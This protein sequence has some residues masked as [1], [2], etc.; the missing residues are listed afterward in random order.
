MQLALGEYPKSV[1]GRCVVEVMNDM[2]RAITVEV[3]NSGNGVWCIIHGVNLNGP[4]Y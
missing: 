2:K 1:N 3:D 4:I